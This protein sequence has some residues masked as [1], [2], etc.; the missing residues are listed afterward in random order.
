MKYIKND[1]NPFSKFVRWFVI[2]VLKIHC[3][4]FYRLKA[5]GLENIP[6]EGS[7]IFCGNHNTL[8]D[9]IFIKITCPRDMRFMAKEELSHSKFL[10]YLGSIYNVIFVKRDSKD[11][12]AIKES[13]STLKSGESLG[14]FPEGTRNGLEKNDGKIKNGASYLAL[15]TKSDIVPIGIINNGFFRKSYI[16]YGKKLDLSKYTESKK[17]DEQ[18]EEEVSELLKQEIIKLS[19]PEEIKLLNK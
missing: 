2:G 16:I 1:I 18:M 11:L 12:S 13:L 6:L 15:K 5:Y 17:V 7:T 4:V 19:N 9:A 3:K 10:N 8:M 14:I